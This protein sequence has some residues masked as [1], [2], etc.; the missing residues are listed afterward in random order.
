MSYDYAF[1]LTVLFRGESNVNFF[2]FCKRNINCHYSLLFYIVLSIFRPIND[3]IFISKQNLNPYPANV[4]NMA[5]VY[6]C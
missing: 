6:Q 3:I 1:V 4:D 5:S 2:N